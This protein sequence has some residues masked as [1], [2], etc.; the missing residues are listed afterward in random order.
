MISWSGIAVVIKSAALAA[1][2]RIK[3]SG[4]GDKCLALAAE[5]TT[6]ETALDTHPKSRSKKREDWIQNR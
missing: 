4:L 3:P 2:H 5:I 1:T 6:F